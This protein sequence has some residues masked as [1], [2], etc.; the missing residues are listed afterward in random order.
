MGIPSVNPTGIT[1]ESLHNQN[2]YAYL[3]ALKIPESVF[4]SLEALDAKLADGLRQIH[5]QEDYNPRFAYA[6]LYT[7]FFTVAEENIKTIF[8]EPRQNLTR[9]LANNIGLKHFVETAA[10]EEAEIDEEK[11][12]ETREFL[13]EELAKRKE[14]EE[15]LAKTR[16]LRTAIKNDLAQTPNKEEDIRQQIRSLDEFILSIYDNDNHILETTFTAIQKIPLEHTPMSSSVEKGIAHFFPSSPSTINLHSQTPAQASSAYGR[17]TAMTTDNFKPQHT[18]SLATIRHYQY[19]LGRRLREYRIGTQA[20]R[21]HGEVRISPLFERWLDLHADAEYDPSK[22]RK[23]THVYFNNLGRDRDDFEGKKEKALTEALHKLEGRHPNLVV[24]TLPADKGLM[25]QSEF[26]K[27]T[28]QHDFKE[29]FDEF[30]KIASQDKTAKNAT[31][32]FYISA[33]AR[34]LIFRNEEKELKKLLQKSFAKIGI[35]EGKPLT[36][37][38]RQ[39]VWFHFI[40]FELTN[41]ILEKLDPNS[42]NFSCKDAIDRGG[43]SSA[44]YNLMKSIEA[45]VPLTREEFERALHA[46]PTVVKARGMNHHSKIIWNT[47]DAYINNNFDTIFNDPKLAWMIEWRDLNCPHSR[48]DDLLSLRL[49]QVQKQL[50]KAQDTASTSEQQFLDL[51]QEVITLIKQ[52]HEL[53]VSGK[54]LLLE[55]VTRTSQLIAQPD[56]KNAAERYQKLA[57]QLTIK[58]PYLNIGVGLLK[59]FSGLLIYIASFGKAHKWLTEGRATRMA[60]LQAD[61]RRTLIDKMDSIK[62]QLKI[63]KI[64]PE[65]REENL[66]AI[67]K[68][69]DS[70]LFKGESGDDPDIISEIK[71]ILQDIHPENSQ[72]YEQELT[73]IKKLIAAKEDNFNEATASVLKA[74]THYGTFKDIRSEL[75]ENPLMQ[76]IMDTEEHVSRNLF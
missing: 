12:N 10:I 39:A 3:R 42:V 45:K 69:L 32:D 61:A 28:D 22:P 49:S 35:E 27:T 24:I 73:K 57:K 16:S 37:A 7:R 30:F 9:Q 65:L 68:L 41:H 70:N 36:S 11:N 66:T 5:Q 33:E 62:N 14:R 8:D 6:D 23:I 31:K 20:Q 4:N 21:H 48:V 60:G 51:E 25:H 29:T 1:S 64:P 46:A 19:N 72:E 63:T 38:Q 67:I 15:S 76:E 34:S 44:Y 71:G 18:T 50:D 47:V 13:P 17:L 75:S 56:N 74:F 53:G 40:K 43:V 52:Q 59:I 58:Y 2:C 26:L 54:R 55:T